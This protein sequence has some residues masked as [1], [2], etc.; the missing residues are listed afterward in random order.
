V[1]VSNMNIGKGGEFRLI[2]Y[3]LPSRQE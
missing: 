3:M 2:E 1:T